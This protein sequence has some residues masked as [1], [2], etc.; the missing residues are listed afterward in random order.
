MSFPSLEK[1]GDALKVGLI[2][3]ANVTSQGNN[4]GGVVFKAS[5]QAREDV[6]SA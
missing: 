2:H 1:L 3:G 6:Q 4:G 5:I